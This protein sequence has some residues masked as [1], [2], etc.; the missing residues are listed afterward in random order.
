MGRAAGGRSSSSAGSDR[1]AITFDKHGVG[2]SDPMPINALP[3][4]EAWI[5]VVRAVMDAP[6]GT[7]LQ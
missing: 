2:M 5:D 7:G 6:A 1:S 3:S 4:I